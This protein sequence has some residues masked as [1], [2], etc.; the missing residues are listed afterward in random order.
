MRVPPWSRAR[1]REDERFAR[2]VDTGD[3]S[4]FGTELAVVAAL[5]RLGEG[6]TASLSG[7]ARARIADRVTPDLRRVKRKP[8]LTAVIT[9]A[10]AVVTAVSGLA[11]VL[12]ANSLPGEALYDVKRAREA[13]VIQL[14]L[15]DESRALKHLEYAELRLAELALL[16]ESGERARHNYAIA[17]D[18][19]TDEAAAGT[20][21][22]T[23]VAT[24]T[25][26]RQLSPLRQ[27]ANE[28]AAKLALL[29]PTL[30]EEPAAPRTL[31]SRIERRATALAARMDCAQITSG[32]F[33]DIGAIPATGA[34]GTPPAEP[35]GT[36]TDPGPPLPPPPRPTPDDERTENTLA[37]LR[38]PVPTAS[39]LP[40][41]SPVTSSTT[42]YGPP[43]PT[44]TMPRLP[45]GSPPPRPPVTIPPLLP[46]LPEVGIG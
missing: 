26:G 28:Q 38:E 1:R 8:R 18:D 22:L 34:C 19:F 4:E 29:S 20:S 7:D 16:V 43:V 15:D 44:P 21:G 27:W 36:R 6:D 24:S 32:D 45:D 40:T 11:L 30:P 12:S 14:T 9:A 35:P 5:R 13:A 41:A 25:G 39:P 33:D 42:V 37:V 23:A 3:D 17:F 10:T 2:A 31:L 46:G